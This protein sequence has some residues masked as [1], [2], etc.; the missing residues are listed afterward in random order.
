MKMTIALRDPVKQTRSVL[1][2]QGVHYLFDLIQEVQFCRIAHCREEFYLK[3][4]LT[5]IY[6]SSNFN[7]SNGI[8]YINFSPHSP[9]CVYS[10]V[11][12]AGAL[13]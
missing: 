10:R 11:L 7:C 13:P 9:I 2:Y 4:I 8:Q 5:Y 12:T 6:K 3:F 1:A